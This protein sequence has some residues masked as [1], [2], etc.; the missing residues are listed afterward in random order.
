MR[1]RIGRIERR[2]RRL[3]LKK[4]VRV[5]AVIEEQRTARFE[6]FAVFFLLQL[7]AVRSVLRTRARRISRWLESALATF[8]AIPIPRLGT[9]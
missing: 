1:G 4:K 2:L 5:G 9:R 3:F 7:S 6:N 8:R